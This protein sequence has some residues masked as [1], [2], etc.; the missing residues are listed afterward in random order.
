MDKATGPWEQRQRRPGMF[1]TFFRG[2]LWVAWSL[3]LGLVTLG[4]LWLLLFG[5]RQL[6]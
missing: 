1:P 6:P 3:F 2:F 4:I 5:W